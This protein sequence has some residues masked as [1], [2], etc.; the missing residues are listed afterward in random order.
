MSPLNHLQQRGAIGLMAAGTLALALLCMLVVLDSGRLYMERRSLQRVADMAALEAA[1]RHGNCLPAT[2]ASAVAFA[3]QSGIRND[4][5]QGNDGRTMTTLCGNLSVDA[6]GMRTFNTDAS[7]YEAI[8]VVVTHPVPRSIA[9]GV[10]SYFSSTPIEP[11][12]SMK[13]TAVAQPAAPLVQLTLRSAAMTLSSANAAVLNPLIGGLL[14]GSLNLSVAGWQGLV[15]TNLNLLSYLTRLST[16]LN[17]KVGDY[18]QLLTTNISVSQLIQSAISVL[19]PNNTLSASA[20]I[21]SLNAIK[22]A[23]GSTTI[24]LGDLLQ[25]QSGSNLAALNTNMRVFDLVQGL[26]QVANKKNGLMSAVQLNV[27]GVAQVTAK[28]QV[29][30]TPQISAIGDPSKIDPSNPTGANRIFVRTAQTRALLSI[31]LPVLGVITPLLNAATNLLTP[32]TP[33]INSVLSLNLVATLSSASCLLGAGCR[34]YD[35]NWLGSGSAGP[36]IDVSVSTSS[37][38]SYVTGFNCTSN[39]NKTLTT[40]T[41]SAL[42]NLKIGQISAAAA[43]PASTDPNAVVALPLP[44]LDIGTHVCYTV[45]GLPLINTPCGPRTAYAGGGLGVSVNSPVGQVQSTSTNFTYTAPSTPN[46]LPE[47]NT[48][49]FFPLTANATLPSSLLAGTIAGVQV[50]MYSPPTNNVLGSLMSGA[51]SL[52]GTITSS[53]DSTINSTLS[54][55]L[56]GV[57]D[58]LLASLGITVNPVNLGANMSCNIGQATL[59]I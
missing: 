41:E 30:Q 49:P 26:V 28:V 3:T 20:A 23:A 11:I 27:P 32:L 51:E 31:N 42:L 40:H 19:D 54:P 2:T 5:V 15:D 34:V 35:Y 47:V 44:V 1:G 24:A 45:L 9:S 8:Q 17:L 7:K 58:P 46:Q 37:A 25:V 29:I 39:T 36:Q 55:L 13:A 14:G 21:S 22:A 50:H 6:S 10:A 4:F 56:T 59:V 43:F 18:T 12:I 57:L 52:L 33:V 38:Q 48:D 16:D 53:L